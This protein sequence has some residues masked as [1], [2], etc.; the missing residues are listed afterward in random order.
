MARVRTSSKGAV[1]IPKSVREA[2][3]LEPGQLVDV[4]VEGKDRIL[5]T[6]LPLDPVEALYGILKGD[7]CG[8]VEDFLRERRREDRARS[9][10]L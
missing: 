4:A 10:R 9:R 8:T 3:G 1:V 6:P 2:V 7:G 5:V